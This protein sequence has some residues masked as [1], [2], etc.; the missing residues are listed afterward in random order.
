MKSLPDLGRILVF[1]GVLLVFVGLG[2]MLLGRTGI[3]FG[4]LPG[5]INFSGRGGSFHFPIVTCLLLSAAAS[6]ILWLV[7][8]LRG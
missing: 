5:D 6:F 3:P 4:R 7:G 2:V 1:A 8:R